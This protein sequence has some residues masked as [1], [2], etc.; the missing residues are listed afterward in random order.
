MIHLDILFVGTVFLSTA[1]AWPTWQAGSNGVQW[2]EYCD[3]SGNDLYSKP[4]TGAQCGDLCAADSK[5]NYFTWTNYNSG[6]CWFKSGSNLQPVQYSNGYSVC[7]YVQRWPT[8]NAGS[9]G[10]QWAENCNFSGHDLYSKPS[11]GAQCG[12]L[13]AADAACNYFTWTQYNSGT[14]WMKS[15]ST[16]QPV[17][18]TSGY[19]V[20]GYVKNK[21]GGGNQV[22]YGRLAVNGK[23]VV[24]AAT[25]QPVQLRGMSLFWSQW[26]SQ[27]YVADTVK[28]LKCSWNANV[29]RAA[30]GVENG[31]YLDYPSVEMQKVY[32]VID[33]AIANGMYVI[34]DWHD[35][36][37]MYHQSQAVDF[38]S[39]VSKKYG[40]YPNIIYETFNEPLQVPWS[41]TLKVHFTKF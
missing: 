9:N 31:G 34:V 33:A 35:H 20:C 37:A 22:P 36:N 14:C 2:A 32:A 16:L 25:G 18:Y 21:S 26:M 5:C 13:C 1:A 29:V 39:Q 11:T 24:S 6:T 40:S 12:D 30:M 7:G 8:W 3:F 38:F 17:Q 15:G 23:Y 10:V 27:F 4:S 41:A 19:S 28:A